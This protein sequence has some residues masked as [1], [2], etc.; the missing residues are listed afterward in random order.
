MPGGTTSWSNLVTLLQ[1]RQISEAITSI[2]LVNITA[3]GPF[4]RL[5]PRQRILHAL[6]FEGLLS[7]RPGTAKF[8]SALAAQ[9]YGF[10]QNEDESRS[11]SANARRLSLAAC[12]FSNARL[13]CFWRPSF[14]LRLLCASGLFITAGVVS[15]NAFCSCCNSRF[16]IC[17]LPGGWDIRIRCCRSHCRGGGRLKK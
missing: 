17:G 6:H 10:T 15:V 16:F 14:S 13:T 1:M 8:T 2:F 3:N 11:R 7:L 9:S 5:A 4:E 12:A